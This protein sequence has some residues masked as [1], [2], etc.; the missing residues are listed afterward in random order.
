MS[1]LTDLILAAHFVGM[2]LLCGSVATWLFWT[3]QALARGRPGT[4]LTF[5]LESILRSDSYF[6]APGAAMVGLSGILLVAFSKL[7]TP[8]L[9]LLPKSAAFIATG[10]IW[11]FVLIP[12]ERNMAR[13]AAERKSNSELPEEFHR[14]RQRWLFFG[15]L[16]YVLLLGIIVWSVLAPH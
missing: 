5:V 9:W 11:R 1:L 3:S 15:C 6:T 4:H 16:N 14:V 7:G 12:A 13:L 8:Q 2:A 10:L